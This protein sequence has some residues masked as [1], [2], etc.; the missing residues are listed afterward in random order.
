M[1]LFFLKNV[2]LCK[3]RI[4]HERNND[5]SP[6]IVKIIR[7]GSVSAVLKTMLAQENVVSEPFKTGQNFS[8]QGMYG[9]AC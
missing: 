4:V 9:Y 8:V 6:H 1:L 2:W 3:P 7:K 5:Y